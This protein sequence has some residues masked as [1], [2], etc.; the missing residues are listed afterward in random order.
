MEA[1]E[2]GF[3]TVHLGFKHRF[4]RPA[5]PR[6]SLINF[7]QKPVDLFFL[8]VDRDIAPDVDD[9]KGIRSDGK[10]KCG[11]MLDDVAHLGL[12][13]YRKP[14]HEF[15]PCDHA[16]IHIGWLGAKRSQ[17]EPGKLR[18]LLPASRSQDQSR[19][20]LCV[21]EESVSRPLGK[22]RVTEDEVDLST[23]LPR[24]G[25]KSTFFKLLGNS[26]GAPLH[27]TAT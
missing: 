12:P 16:F 3:V 21:H 13:V 7:A 17:E 24:R 1:V 27:H 5:D 15:A 19:K 2:L 20:H 18:N 4:A 10:G 26:G 14:T 9:F 11:V 6:E 23:G 8:P 22:I 25:D